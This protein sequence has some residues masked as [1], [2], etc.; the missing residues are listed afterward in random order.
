MKRDDCSS[1]CVLAH[2]AGGANYPWL[3]HIRGGVNYIEFEEPAGSGNWR[4]YNDDWWHAHC[5]VVDHNPAQL[6]DSHY[7]FFLA[8]N[9][10][11]KLRFHWNDGSISAP[12]REYYELE[13]QWFAHNGICE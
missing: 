11:I 6:V 3:A 8:P 13:A 10:P 5:R 1:K 9:A 4:T 12:T 7:A 2:A